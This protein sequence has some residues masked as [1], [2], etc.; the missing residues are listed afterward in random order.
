MEAP[1]SLFTNP[2]HNQMG[3][4]G[5]VSDPFDYKPLLPVR[6]PSQNVTQDNVIDKTQE[7]IQTSEEKIES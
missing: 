4:K 5:D 3:N 1:E 7:D 6:T 2:Y